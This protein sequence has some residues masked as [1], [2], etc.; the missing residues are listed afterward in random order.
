MLARLELPRKIPVAFVSRSRCWRCRRSAYS[1][2]CVRG[3]SRMQT[4][5]S[6]VRP[7]S[8]SSSS[9]ATV[10]SS[11]KGV[12]R[13]TKPLT[14]AHLAPSAVGEPAAKAAVADHGHDP[15]GLS[16]QR[17]RP[18]LPDASFATSTCAMHLPRAGLPHC[19][20]AAR[21]GIHPAMCTKRSSFWARW[22]YAPA[23]PDLSQ[24]KRKTFC[25]EEL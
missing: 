22:Q 17:C 20:T 9:R 19:G 7:E 10:P 2:P 23:F 15:F 5:R 3:P 11:R 12:R 6:G 18:G 16:R 8:A 14:F 21:L 1:A 4:R 25:R 13:R 24:H